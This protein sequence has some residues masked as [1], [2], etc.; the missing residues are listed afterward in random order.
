MVK[1][2]LT[3]PFHPS[4]VSVAVIT[5]VAADAGV[6]GVPVIAPVDA[7]NDKPAGSEPVVTA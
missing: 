2:M 7:F 4:T 3:V 5:I 6:V 1:V